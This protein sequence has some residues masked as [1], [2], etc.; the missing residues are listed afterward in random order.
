MFVYCDQ[1]D[2]YCEGV[3]VSVKAHLKSTIKLKSLCF[4]L[5]QPSGSSCSISDLMLKVFFCFFLIL[6][7]K[8]VLLWLEV[9]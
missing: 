6:T 5:D 2:V 7:I 4:C 9:P 3:V 1:L 8:I